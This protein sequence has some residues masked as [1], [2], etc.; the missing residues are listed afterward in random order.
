[1]GFKCQQRINLT[2][3]TSFTYH[4]ERS[5]LLLL[6]VRRTAGDAI[7][8]WIF[9]VKDHIPGGVLGKLGTRQ[10]PVRHRLDSGEPSL[11]LRWRVREQRVIGVRHGTSPLRRSTSRHERVP[12]AWTYLLLL[13]D[14]GI[15]DGRRI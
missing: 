10:H 2:N 6:L 3:S 8:V 7:A 4:H 11:L 5:L 9:I 1:M 14:A 12:L 13:L 15:L